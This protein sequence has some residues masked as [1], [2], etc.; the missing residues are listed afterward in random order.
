M[1]GVDHQGHVGGLL[2][3]GRD[4]LGLGNVKPQSLHARQGHGGR[5]A[6]GGV[7]L[8]GATRQQ[9]A[10][11]GQADAS[12]GACDEDDG[13]LNVHE[14]LQKKWGYGFHMTLV[15]CIGEQKSDG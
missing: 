10:G 15:I 4:L 13:V 7:D 3:G 6:C 14:G 11:K 9:F 8:A 12:V 2:C 5:V 1:P